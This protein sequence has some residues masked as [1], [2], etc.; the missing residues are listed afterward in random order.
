MYVVVTTI[1]G[2]GCMRQCRRGH[3]WRGSGVAGCALFCGLIRANG[4]HRRWHGVLSNPTHEGLGNVGGIGDDR[5]IAI[6][7]ADTNADLIMVMPPPRPL[8]Q[9]LLALCEVVG[10]V[11]LT[12]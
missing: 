4:K 1:V 3:R 10:V 5:P 2:G 7:S 11:M 9:M 6:N 12:Y 8:Y